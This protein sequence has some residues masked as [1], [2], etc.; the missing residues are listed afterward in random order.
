MKIESISSVTIPLNNPFKRFLLLLLVGLIFFSFY[1][2]SILVATPQTTRVKIV[3]L[4]NT[5]SEYVIVV[6]EPAESDMGIKLTDRYA[7]SLDFQWLWDEPRSRA[8]TD[9]D[10]GTYETMPLTPWFICNYRF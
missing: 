9:Q 3:G 6:D 10:F 8:E 2:C 4:H 7:I 1:G 5:I